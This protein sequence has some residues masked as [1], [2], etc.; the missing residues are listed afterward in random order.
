MLGRLAYDHWVTV[1]QHHY[2]NPFKDLCVM[3]IKWGEDGE[4]AERIG[5]V[6]LGHRIWDDECE[7]LRVRTADPD[8]PAFLRP[9]DLEKTK[10]RVRLE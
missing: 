5:L 4:T 10:R 7:D 9:L 1:D 2:N 6:N 8:F 3:V